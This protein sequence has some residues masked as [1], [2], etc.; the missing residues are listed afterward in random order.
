MK[1]KLISLIAIFLFLSI[2]SAYANT[3]GVEG[4]IT[5]KGKVVEIVT[6]LKPD[7]LNA[8]EGSLIQEQQIVKVRVMSGEFKGREYLVEN[9]MG[10]NEYYNIRVEE[11]DNILLVLDTTT[12]QMQVYI[13]G[14]ARDTYEIIIILMFVL[15]LLAV[16]R[17]K[18]LKSVITLTITLVVILKVI[19]PAIISGRNPI[20]VSVAGSIVITVLTLTIVSG[21]NRKSLS[22]ILGTL[23]GVF[24]AGGIAY[25]IGTLSKLTGLNSEEAV[26][27][28]YIPGDIDLNLKGILFAGILIGTL[29][30]VMDV[31][32]SIASSMHEIKRIKS[33]ISRKDL[34]KSG[35]NV[36]RDIMGTMSNT[37]ILAYTG[38]SIPILIIFTAYNISFIEIVNLDVMATEIIRAV[39]GSI[40]IILSIPLTAAITV[41][42]E[43]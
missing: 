27:L 1:K 7:D 6:H 29:G 20:M 10:S 16:G 25:V 30:A 22:A 12:D 14:F 33:D 18:G 2:I 26:M 43:K 19:V 36:G 40:G 34:F 32:M 31:S 15:L 8:G 11:G 3:G 9:N 37:L 13:S 39:A 23:S 24:M 21:I 17:M 42:T 41:F 28:M 5:V 35:M 4:L 38:A